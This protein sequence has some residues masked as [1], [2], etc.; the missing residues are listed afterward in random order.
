LRLFPTFPI[1]D[2]ITDCVEDLVEMGGDPEFIAVALENLEDLCADFGN[3]DLDTWETDAD[4]NPTEPDQDLQQA[5]CPNA[6]SGNGDCVQA[7]CVCHDDWKGADCSIDPSKPPVATELEHEFCD[8]RGLAH[9]P[10]AVSVFGSNIFPS[11][12]IKCRFGDEMTNGV[13]L[14]TI[15]IRCDLP[16]VEQN[17][18]TEVTRSVAIS[19]DGEQFS[20]AELTFTWYDSACEICNTDGCSANPES[21][22]IDN[23]CHIDGRLNDDNICEKCNVATSSSAW[24]FDYS[25]GVECGPQ[26]SSVSYRASIVGFAAAGTELV[27]VSAANPRVVADTSNSITYSIR[28]ESTTGGHTLAVDSNGVVTL[29]EDLTVTE[30]V[31][32]TGSFANLVH[33]IATD[34]HGNVDEAEL[35]IE[36]QETNQKP[37]F[38]QTSYTFEVAENTAVGSEVA[39]VQAQDPDGEGAWANVVYSWGA[40]TSGQSEVFT[41]DPSTGAITVGK[42]LDYE[43]VQSYTFQLLARDGGGQ[44]HTTEIVFNIVDVNEAPSNLALSSTEV[45][46]NQPIGTVVGVLSADDQDAGD[47]LT[48]S[49]TSPSSDFAVQGNQLVTARVFDFEQESDKSFDVEISAA[50]SKDLASTKIFTITVTN[51]NEPPT[52]VTIDRTT[53]PESTR[54]GQIIANIAFDD[55]DNQ[56]EDV[57]CGLRETDAGHFEVANNKLTLIKELDFETKSQHVISIVCAD[58]DGAAS[59]EATFTLTIT[60]ANDGPQNMALVLNSGSSVS[61]DTPIGTVIGQICAEDYDSDVSSIGF[62]IIETN[63]AFSLGEVSCGVESGVFVCTADVVVATELDF[64]TAEGPN[65]VVA[66]TVEAVDNRDA[67]E[68]IVIEV[69]LSDVNED[70]TAVEWLSGGSVHANSE[71]GTVVGEIIVVDDDAADVFTFQLSSHEGVFEFRANRRRT[72]GG[73]AT[74]ELVVKDISS[75][76]AGTEETVQIMVSTASNDF[77]FDISVSVTAEPVVVVFADRTHFAPVDENAADGTVV[78]RVIVTGVDETPSFS[79]NPRPN[80]VITPFAFRGNRLIVNGEINYEQHQAFI[81]DVR[82]EFPASDREAISSTHLQIYVNDIDELPLF[83]NPVTEINVNDETNRGTTIASYTVA[84]PEGVPVVLTLGPQQVEGL[85]Y[86]RGNDLRFRE[87]ANTEVEVGTYTLVLIATAGNE[88][89]RLTVTV[90]IVDDCHNVDCGAGRC[91]DLFKAYECD[92]PNGFTGEHCENTRGSGNGSGFSQSRASTGVSTAATAGIVVGVIAAIVLAIVVVILVVRRGRVEKQVLEWTEEQRAFDNPTFAAADHKTYASFV[93]GV[94]NPLYGWYKPDMT[95]QEASSELANAAYGSF[96]VRDSKATPGWHILGVRT[97]QGVV[98]DK[99]RKTEDGQY[100]LLPTGDTPQPS[101]NDLPDLVQYYGSV[102]D[103]VNYALTTNS[104]DNP[105]YAA[106]FDVQ[107]PVHPVHEFTT[108]KRDAAAPAVPL[109]EKERAAVALLAE[110]EE[111][112][113]NTA[114]ASQALSRA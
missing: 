106:A 83:R 62:S 48:F 101:F 6:C 68:E 40:V 112:Y 15:E 12:S 76:A 73:S 34:S 78:G 67:M 113:T 19:T 31:R 24:S 32:V 46:E 37:V 92:C 111:L 55:V 58:V 114:E 7:K 60:N 17:G 28:G 54:V 2:F 97:P 90:N 105:M 91:V 108:W 80:G 27:T 39:V 99:I 52:G 85:F 35:F 77:T 56:A 29:T 49:L 109:K 20:T 36:L 89:T 84:D 65:H 30:D 102:H 33:V 72:V 8:T 103:G 74:A 104:F 22:T 57:R 98:H 41:V 11:D 71:P 5:M 69:P 86:L 59:E 38:E 50:D 16:S 81:V 18:A 23:V 14:S 61:E 44:F 42:P 21:C 96:Y 53:I 95:R 47:S 13:F 93:P 88:E 75:L 43:N 51:V 87:Q 45:A 82:A 94:A 9:C 66:F 64:E 25:N 79:I 100:E 3:R 4:G 70:P 63:A 10:S 26:F 1:D 107:S 110:Q